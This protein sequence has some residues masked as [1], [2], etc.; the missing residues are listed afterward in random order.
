MCLLVFRKFRAGIFGF[1]F[2]FLY[3]FIKELYKSTLSLLGFI[4][5]HRQE[6]IHNALADH[7]CFFRAFSC[8][9]NGNQVGLLGVFDFKE[10]LG[11]F[12]SIRF[13]F[14]ILPFQLVDNR[15]QNSTGFH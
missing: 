6:I 9:R 15:F 2:R 1:L 11:E 3:A 10:F 13:I 14:F 12:L 5:L 4:G 7:L 8:G